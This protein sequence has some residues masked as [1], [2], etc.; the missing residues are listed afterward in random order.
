MDGVGAELSFHTS[1]VMGDRS[2]SSLVEKCSIF[3]ANNQIES[4]PIAKPTDA[5]NESTFSAEVNYWL[6]DRFEESAHEY[7]SASRCLFDDASTPVTDAVAMTT[8][9]T[10]DDEYRQIS[11]A[12]GLFG[13]STSTTKSF[14]DPVDFSAYFE[15]DQPSTPSQDTVLVGFSDARRLPSPQYQQHSPLCQP[16]DADIAGLPAC[17]RL[18]QVLTQRGYSPLKLSPKGFQLASDTASATVPTALINQWAESIVQCTHELLA[19]LD[20]ARAA[21]QDVSYSVRKGGLSQEA[22]QTR[23]VALEGQLKQARRKA[24]SAELNNTVLEEERVTRS[25]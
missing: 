24:T 1:A 4:S 20:S 6:G 23:V 22:L 12:G 7:D 21:V 15:G 10:T 3:D 25:R 17:F 13:N 5:N 11:A 8:A 19:Q 16:A 2:P 9:P 18:N 14:S